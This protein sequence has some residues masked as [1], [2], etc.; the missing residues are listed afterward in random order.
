MGKVQTRA[1]LCISGAL[2]TTPTEALNVI[3]H[4]PALDLIARSLALTTAVRL[5]ETVGWTQSNS[6]QSSILNKVDY[7]A[8]QTD[9][10]TRTLTFTKNYKVTIPT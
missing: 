2:T 7:I 3:L 5:M 4:L 1:E 10:C 8:S 9:Y 6:G